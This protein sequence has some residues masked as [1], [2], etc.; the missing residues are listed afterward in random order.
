MTIAWKRWVSL[1]ALSALAAL[2]GA[3]S[4][5]EPQPF[6]CTVTLVT[7]NGRQPLGSITEDA[8]GTSE[9]QDRCVSDRSSSAG[10]GQTIECSC[11]ET[12]S[13]SN[14]VPSLNITAPSR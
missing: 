9:A 1:S 2:G 5:E 4:N 6:L 10:P 13:N 11:S 3:C 14:P 12:G 7:P 8:T